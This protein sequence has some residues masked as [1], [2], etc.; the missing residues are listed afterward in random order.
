MLNTIPSVREQINT[1]DTMISEN[2]RYVLKGSDDFGFSISD[3]SKNVIRKMIDNLVK[4]RLTIDVSS[5]TNEI[6]EYYLQQQKQFS[7]I[8]LMR[9]KI[10]RGYKILFKIDA[11]EPFTFFKKTCECDYLPV[12]TVCLNEV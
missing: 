5:F 4:N 2:L 1:I 12:D 6:T 9:D 8:D 3:G 7:D 11:G 10:S